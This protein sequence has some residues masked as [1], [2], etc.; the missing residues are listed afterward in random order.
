MSNLSSIIKKGTYENIFV[1]CPYCRRECIF[2]RIS[3]LKTVMPIAGQDLKCEYCGRIFWASCDRVTTASYKWFLGDLPILIKNKAY[4]LYILALCQACEMFMHQAIINKLIDTNPVYRNNEGHFS[5][6]NKVGADAYNEIYHAFRE[7]PIKDIT[8][9]G[10]NDR[11]KYKECAFDALRKLFMHVF[12]SARTNALPSLH[13]LKEDKRAQCFCILENTNINQ[14]RNDIVHKHAYRPSFCD[15]QK[16]D[17]L[18]DCLYW[19]G[20]YLDVKDSISHLNT[21]LLRDN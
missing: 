3:D 6:N 7:K 10:L 2:N 15:I 13:K 12:D 5:A 19:M 17:E 4:G 18:I 21:M 20:I 14:T 16:Y 1:D 9:N 11:R 8:N